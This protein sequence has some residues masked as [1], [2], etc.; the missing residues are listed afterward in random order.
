MP[1]FEQ[2]NFK[3]E[4]QDNATKTLNKILKTL[5]ELEKKMN[6]LSKFKMPNIGLTNQQIKLLNN[7][8]KL[9][10]KLQKVEQDLKGIGKVQKQLQKFEIVSKGKPLFTYDSATQSYVDNNLGVARR[11][12]EKIQKQLEEQGI[13]DLVKGWGKGQLALP[14]PRI[15]DI[16]KSFSKN[17]L[18]LPVP[19]LIM[20]D[21]KNYKPEFVGATKPD[22]ADSLIE[23]ENYITSEL[24]KYI[25]NR[26]TNLKQ[27][28]LNEILNSLNLKENFNQLLLNSLNKKTPTDSDKEIAKLITELNNYK[29][30]IK[31]LKSLFLKTDNQDKLNNITN[32]LK[33]AIENY[34][35]TKN[36]IIELQESLKNQTTGLGKWSEFGKDYLKPI[37]T[38]EKLNKDGSVT[39]TA[40]YSEQIGD[41]VYT[42]EVVNDEIKKITTQ[43]KK[44]QKEANKLKK[45]FKG[46]QKFIKSI[47]KIVLYRAIRSAMAEIKKAIQSSQ[48]DLAKFDSGYNETLSKLVTSLDV[49]KASMGLI[50]RPF[51][52][53]IEPVIGNIVDLF[54]QVGNYIS[55]ATAKSKGLS[56]YIKINSDYAKDFLESLQQA[57]NL[58]SF[59]KFEVLQ[60]QETKDIYEKASVADGI[61]ASENI[62]HIGDFIMNGSTS[63]ESVINILEQIVKLLEPLRLLEPLSTISGIVDGI[64][65]VVEGI[66]TL[67]FDLLNTGI[68]RIIAEI[69]ISIGNIFIGLV[70]M[71]IKLFEKIFSWFGYDVDLKGLD[72]LSLNNE[73]LTSASNY[74]NNK[75]Y[76]NDATTV[77]NSLDQQLA[78]KAVVEID[79]KNVNNN[80]IARELAG[81]MADQFK[82]QNIKVSYT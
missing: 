9:D 10:K 7:W 72:Y 53:V 82:K 76:G 49:L 23:D 24:E 35:K 14:M 68:E 50:I 54:A 63:L 36:K 2:L 45:S 20:P 18:S 15:Q 13:K 37:K 46:V 42:Y 17:Q 48:E 75:I 71:W 59:D 5:T 57:N 67:N 12:R 25:K 22:W 64:L 27:K 31:K 8:D 73:K 55:Y 66:F 1:D 19:K 11:E 51:V 16:I 81:S 69:V 38:F 61:D 29:N 34:K 39:K 44:A 52:E 3:V 47:G 74:A 33:I 32:N 41:T 79:F 4:A 78:S 30:E 80:A 40:F 6:G 70:N 60:K 65:D 43:T 58:L 26:E 77:R 62:K 56:N 21:W 28:Q